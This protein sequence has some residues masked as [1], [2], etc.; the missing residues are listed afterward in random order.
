MRSRGLN[1]KH[2]KALELLKDGKLS[3]IEVAKQSGLGQ[4]QL[5]D[6]LAGDEHAG[7]VA[8]EFSLLYQKVMDDADRRI[9][10][11]QKILKEGLTEI[12]TEWMNESRGKKLKLDERK[13]LTNAA[14]V[15]QVGPVYNVGSVSFATGLNAEE[16]KNE[17]RRLRGVVESA[18]DRRPVS[19]TVEGRPG[20]L[21]LLAEAGDQPA[22]SEETTRVRP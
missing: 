18:L 2:K 12:L 9:N 1:D 16:M 20:V 11:K 4:S 13:A 21:S 6:L 22:Q 5:F 3:V 19:D 17:F 10:S 8:A 14:K 15:L 7:G